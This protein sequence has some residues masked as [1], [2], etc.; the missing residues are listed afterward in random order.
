MLA[1]L[2]LIVYNSTKYVDQ[3]SNKINK[4]ELSGV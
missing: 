2:G 1:K 3:T 4:C